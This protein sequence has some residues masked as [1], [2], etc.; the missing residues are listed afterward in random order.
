MNLFCFGPGFSA[1]ALIARLAPAAWN[2][3]VTS[4]RTGDGDGLAT[5]PFDG[6]A[7][8]PDGALDG[9][10][11]VLSSVPPDDDGDPVVRACAAQL[12]AC[13]TLQWVGYLSTTG[14]Y[15][16]RQGG[17]VDESSELRPAG[18]RG[19]RRVTAERQWLDLFP[20]APPAVQVFRLAG[21]YG[22]GRGPF[23]ALRD[24]TARRIVK[25][26]Q[27]FSRI[28]VDDIATVLAASIA[29]PEAGGIYNVCDDNPAP[30]QDVVAHAAMLL[31]VE[32][33]PEIPF[34]EAELSPMAR[35][36]Y[37]E[38]KRVANDRIKRVLGVTLRYPG[39]VEGLPAVLAAERAM[40]L[41]D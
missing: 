9:V 24:G 41:S 15:G 39:Y 10:T 4:R 38:S 5:V 3:R 1:R 27:V 11:H 18:R 20:D 25:P 7:P 14:V 8:L 29:R 6:S 2:V 17:V 35:S 21:I 40:G 32:P 28:H 26:G 33:P 13:S 19:E 31:G 23:R 16:D 22:P 34:A 12:R 30:P 37:G 36:F